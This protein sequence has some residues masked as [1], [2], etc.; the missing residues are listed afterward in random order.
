MV[1][2]ANMAANQ[3]ILSVKINSPDKVIWEGEASVV[4][5]I[6]SKGPFDILPLH[7]NFITIVENKPIKIKTIEDKLIDF[8]FPHAVLY[9]HG[10]KVLIYTNI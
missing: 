9:I 3:A 2:D 5:S 1:Y 7:A 10:N 6:N 8:T 4:S